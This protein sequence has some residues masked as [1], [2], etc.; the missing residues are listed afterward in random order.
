[1][2]AGSAQPGD[3]GA[4]GKGPPG[5]VSERIMPIN[6]PNLLTL[7]RIALVP[8]MI[9][10]LV[11]DDGGSLPLA[12]AVFGIAALTDV[13]D[14]HVARARNMITTFGRIVDSLADKLLVGAALITLVAIDRLALW[15]AVV[16]IFREVAVSALRWYAG[17]RGIVVAVNRFGK[18]KAGVQMT[19]I[20]L[21]MLVPDP[22]AAWVTALMLGVVAVTVASGVQYFLTYARLAAATPAGVVPAARW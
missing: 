9:L 12:A 22:G 6:P 8:V 10:L 15:I 14:G 18:S 20:L 19:S 21:L 13:A 17:T 7:A 5:R 11:G 1:V 3:R 4:P 16:I 2:S